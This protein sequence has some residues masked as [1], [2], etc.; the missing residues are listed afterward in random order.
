MPSASFSSSRTFRR[1]KRK[2]SNRNNSGR[3]KIVQFG[4]MGLEEKYMYGTK[5]ERVFSTGCVCS[6]LMK[7]KYLPA[8]M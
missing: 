1:S 8:K 3:K 7:E 6:G 4:Q 5:M 2:G